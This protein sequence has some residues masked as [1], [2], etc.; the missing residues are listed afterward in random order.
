MKRTFTL[1]AIAAFAANVS[2]QVISQ[3]ADQTTVTALNSVACGAQGSY[4]ADNSY[5]R[6]F[7]LADYAITYDY[8]ITNVK[9]G[10]EN[11][12]K[13]LNVNVNLHSLVGS[14]PGGSLTLLT[15]VPVAV[16]SANSLGL[17]DTGTDLTQVIP[18]GSK[19]VLEVF[20]N[21]E[22]PLEIFYMGTNASAQTGP[23]YI[24]ALKCGITT[25]TATGTGALASFASARWVMTITG[26]NNLG[27]TEIINSKDLQVYP[28]PAKDVLNFKMANNMQVETVE[29]YDMTGR[30]VNTVT[31]KS[32]KDVNVSNL[33]KG[34][35]ILKAKA[36][37][38]KVYVQKVLKD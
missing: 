26:V 4:T 23:S 5:T 34:T 17:V 24:K 38:G 11:V 10:V 18:A 16:T 25:P 6:A 20:H 1:L 19:I 31:A 29:L 2:S 35:Y 33:R 22:T 36:N 7:D 32:V 27:V 9:F 13:A 8:K 21:G 37:D 14:Y 15:S 3:N 30:K 28:N 12:N